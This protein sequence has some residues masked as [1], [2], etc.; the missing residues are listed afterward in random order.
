MS[1]EDITLNSQ[2]KITITAK[3]EI[4]ISGDKDKKSAI[5]INKDE[6]NITGNK[7]STIVMNKDGVSIK[8]KQVKTN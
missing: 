5:K 6:M 1:A 4:N 2:K 3:D 8:G 7:D